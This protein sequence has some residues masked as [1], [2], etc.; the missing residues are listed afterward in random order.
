MNIERTQF[1]SERFC[2]ADHPSFGCRIV[3]LASSAQDSTNRRNINNLPSFLRDHLPNHCFAAVEGARQ[4]RFDEGIPILI[5]HQHEEIVPNE[6]YI[7]DQD[8]N[9]SI[10]GKGFLYH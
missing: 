1:S 3:G 2:E 9:S 4:I 6:T 10:L 8:I 5:T 7:I